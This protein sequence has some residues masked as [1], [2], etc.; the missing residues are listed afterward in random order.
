MLR[1]H[2]TKT[3]LP[4]VGIILAAVVGFPSARDLYPNGFKSFSPSRTFDSVQ[5]E[6]GVC[7]HLG[8]C[9]R[10]NPLHQIEHAE[11]GRL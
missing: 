2:E 4:V 5:S 7:G 10:V 8:Q 9:L 3:T 11:Y 6:S 1:E